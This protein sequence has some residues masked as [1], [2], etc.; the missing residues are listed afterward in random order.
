MK[1]IGILTFHKSINNGAFLQCFSLQS[2]IKNMGYDVEIIDFDNERMN[3]MYFNLYNSRLFDAHTLKE[4]C[5]KIIYRKKDKENRLLYSKF[6]DSWNLLPLSKKNFIFNGLSTDLTDFINENYDLLV[7]G[8]DAVFNWIKRG[9]PNPY[10]SIEGIKIPVISYAASSFGMDKENL[11]IEELCLFSKTLNQMGKI[12]VR[13]SYTKSFVNEISNKNVAEV[14]DPTFFLKLDEIK[15]ILREK[16]NVDIKFPKN[17]III[18]LVGEIDKSIIKKLH[19]NKQIYLVSTTFYNK[20]AD[21]Y[22]CSLSPF[23]WAL[24]FK[25]FDLTI[26]NLFHGTLLSLKNL[27]PCVSIDV[28]SFSSRYEGKIFDSL[29]KLDLLELYCNDIDDLDNFVKI[30]MS[31]IEKRDLIVSKI[32]KSFNC[33]QLKSLDWLSDALKENL[34]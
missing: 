6:K 17:K 13:D 25:Y 7:I 34:K 32:K 23:E 12:S 29:K 3:K 5:S 14:Y 19:K 9:F 27:V 22:I 8:S 11:S 33:D 31:T 1:K 26:T 10:V 30:V 16:T 2:I 21:R 18:G 4:F 28:S 20:G 24:I 15:N